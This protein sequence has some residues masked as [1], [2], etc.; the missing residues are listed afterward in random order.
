MAPPVPHPA[1]GERLA[2]LRRRSAGI[3]TGEPVLPA[4]A[5]RAAV[6]PRERAVHSGVAA[7]GVSDALRAWR[8]EQARRRGVPPYVI[9][10]DRTLDAIASSLPGSRDE[11]R[12]LP[13]IGPAKLDA[14]GDAIL[15]IVA[16]VLSRT[17]T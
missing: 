14:H 16:A 7:A 4:L 13:G 17:R 1:K 8:I 15:A 6:V 11:L 5:S 9:L 3:R 10:H 12:S 2:P